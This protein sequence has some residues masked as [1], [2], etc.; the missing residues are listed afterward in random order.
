MILLLISSPPAYGNLANILSASGQK[1]EAELAYRK[2]LTFR[3]NMAD[4][5]Y[6]LYVFDPIVVRILYLSS[7]NC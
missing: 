3:Y 1:H 2:A 7:S 6:N 4:V 5:H